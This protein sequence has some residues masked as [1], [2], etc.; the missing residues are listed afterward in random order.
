MSRILV[1]GD[2]HL[3]A[4]RPDVAAHVQVLSL[5]T[6]GAGRA[7]VR[8]LT[9]SAGGMGMLAYGTPQSSAFVLCIIAPPLLPCLVLRRAPQRLTAQT[10]VG[11]HVDPQHA[12][13]ELGVVHVVHCRRRVLR[14]HELHKAKATVLAL[15]AC[16]RPGRTESARLVFTGETHESPATAKRRRR[17]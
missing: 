9:A 2:L 14:L 5:Q 7:A 11:G 4:E 3:P 10:L 13:E 6:H 12:P 1:I 17:K 16:A 8:P 15:G